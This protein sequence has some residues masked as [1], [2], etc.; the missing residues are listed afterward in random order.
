MPFIRTT[1]NEKL[2]NEQVKSLSAEFGKAIEL[3]PGKSEKWL[4]LA[5]EDGIR[6]AFGGK[7]DGGMAMVEVQ[8]LGSAERES[9]DALTAALTSVVSSVIGIAPESVYINYTYFDTWGFG[10]SNL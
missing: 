7:S 6:M 5:F 8:L 3:I 2:S 9:L 10:G 4:M 1:T